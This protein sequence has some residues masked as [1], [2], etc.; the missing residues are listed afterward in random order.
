VAEAQAVEFSEEAILEEARRTTGLADFGD[1]GFREG[2]RVLLRTYEETAGFNAKGRVRNHRRVV[3]L[4]QNRLRIQ[5]A[6]V[7]HP[8]IRER[9]IASPVVLTGLPRSGTSALFNLLGADPAA[10]PLLLWEA[11]FPWP[12]EGQPGASDPRRDAVE[13]HYQRGREK[14]PDF[15]RI[16]YVSAD[17]PEECVL[18]LAHDFCD[19]QMGIEPLMEPYASWFPKQDLRR[20][21]AYY[22]DLLRLL[23][24][25]RPGERWTLKTP[26][27][28]WALDV[29]IETF[30]DI[31]LVW[32]H[33][34]PLECVASISSMTA[35]LMVAREGFDL[36]G[37]GPLVMEYYATSLERGLEARE[38]SDP[39]RF[40]D[41]DYDRFVAD[42]Q[43]V[44]ESIYTH[45]GLPSGPQ[46][47]SA[48]RAHA[49]AHPQGAH[50]R[51][52]YS[53]EQYGL[54]SERVRARFGDYIRRYALPSS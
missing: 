41:V 10:R 11:L 53:L 37:L 46:V 49:E 38:R 20:S 27:H 19:V 47:Q 3:Q 39:A 6:L 7:R 32:T 1:E 28:L 30:P 40:V 48:L 29:L 23:D 52:D 15:T 8:E 2:L 31:A 21:Y 44:A 25:Q 51:H 9:R 54:T 18:L 34:N 42:P 17:T 43:G 22:A 45:F 16:H 26:A 13:A 24:W 35:A 4:L 5:D 33:R 12:L 36:R 14:N 50:G